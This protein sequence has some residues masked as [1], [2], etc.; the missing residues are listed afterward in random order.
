MLGYEP[1]RPSFW[2]ALLFIA[3]L[4]ALVAWSVRLFH[5]NIPA[6]VLIG[7]AIPAAIVASLT[8]HVRM[9]DDW[10]S[11]WEMNFAQVDRATSVPHNIR[12]KR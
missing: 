8:V 1:P 10:R 12:V 6:P 7:I 4:V 2:K 5:V 11:K 3:P 9:L